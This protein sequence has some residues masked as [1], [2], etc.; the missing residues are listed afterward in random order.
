[1]YGSIPSYELWFQEGSCIW[2]KQRERIHVSDKP[3]QTINAKGGFY[4]SLSEPYHFTLV[5]FFLFIRLIP[6]H[7]FT[8]YN[9]SKDK[10][11]KLP[12]KDESFLYQP[13]CQTYG[14]PQKPENQLQEQHND[15]KYRQQIYNQQQ[16]KHN[17]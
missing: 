15:N 12:Y 16:F 17:V 10:N 5:R 8:A 6:G 3:E 7:D 13:D 11:D 9:Y 2:K 1:M 4:L 14:N